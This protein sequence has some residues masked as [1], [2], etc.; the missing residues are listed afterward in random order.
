M[1]ILIVILIEFM[2]IV[3]SL[4]VGK[5]TFYKY[6]IKVERKYLAIFTYMLLNILWI[7]QIISFIK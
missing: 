3:F 6:D 2:I 4:F 5:T 1:S 7:F